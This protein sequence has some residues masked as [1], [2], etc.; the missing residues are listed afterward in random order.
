MQNAESRHHKLGWTF[1]WMWCWRFFCMISQLLRKHSHCLQ[2]QSC[3]SFLGWSNQIH[4]EL[5]LWRKPSKR[6]VDCWTQMS[7]FWTLM[8]CGS[9]HLFSVCL[10]FVS[11]ERKRRTSDLKCK[12]N[13]TKKQCEDCEEQTLKRWSGFCHLFNHPSSNVLINESF[14]RKISGWIRTVT[15]N[16][17]QFVDSVTLFE[18]KSASINHESCDICHCI[19]LSMEMDFKETNI[20]KFCS[21][22][23]NCRETHTHCQFGLKTQGRSAMMFQKSSKDCRL[24]NRCSFRESLCLFQLNLWSLVNWKQQGMCVSLNRTW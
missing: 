18:T 6:E 11:T 10:C 21:E 19:S 17:Q 4:H 20:F 24:A 3:W 8:T 7:C 16:H 12:K 22:K 1:G 14:F 13:Q 9:F 23:G 2:R 15:V 5:M